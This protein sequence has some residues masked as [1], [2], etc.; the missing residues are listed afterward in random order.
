MSFGVL[1]EGSEPNYLNLYPWQDDDAWMKWAGPYMKPL[2]SKQDLTAN[3]PGDPPPLLV[4]SRP[5][6]DPQSVWV[7]PLSDLAVTVTDSS[8][9]RTA[10]STLG[11]FGK[12]PYEVHTMILRELD[13]RTLRRLAS[14]SSDARTVVDGLREYRL[15]VEH[16]G[17]VLGTLGQMRV[18]HLITLRQLYETLTNPSCVECGRT[19][20]FI[21]ALTGQR[22]C[23]DCLENKARFW[24]TDAWKT[25]T[26]FGLRPGE[27]KELAPL[28]TVKQAGRKPG[29]RRQRVFGQLDAAALALRCRGEQDFRRL[30]RQNGSVEPEFEDRDFLRGDDRAPLR[31]PAE[32][33]VERWGTQFMEMPYVRLD[34]GAGARIEQI[35]WCEGCA[36]PCYVNQ[37]VQGMGHIHG[38]KYERPRGKLPEWSALAWAARNMNSMSESMLSRAFR[39][40]TMPELAAHLEVCP[41]VPLVNKL[42][43][44]QAK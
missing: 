27:L 40:R 1:P 5:P 33:N 10:Y 44:A 2:Q 15:L 28:W 39:E 18:A 30:T 12:L 35:A 26:M 38:S 37:F 25:R 6:M 13:M 24:V 8:E 16:A 31:L 19:G 36:T 22:A 9:R 7:E 4:L 21:Y 17:A 20:A 34:G 32:R 41:G 11:G 14:L 23:F 42:L 43:A 3:S 29:P